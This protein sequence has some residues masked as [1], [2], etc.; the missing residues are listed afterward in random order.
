MIN[1]KPKSKKDYFFFFLIKQFIII[2]LITFSSNKAN[3]SYLNLITAS[4]INVAGT[5][6]YNIINTFAPSLEFAWEN[7]ARTV[8]KFGL[9]I[10]SLYMEKNLLTKKTNLFVEMETYLNNQMNFH[11]QMNFLEK[12]LK[13]FKFD[14]KNLELQKSFDDKIV[15]LQKSFDDKIVELKK[16]LLE[17][18]NKDF[19]L[20]SLKLC[21]LTKSS[22]ILACLLL[23]TKKKYFFTFQDFFSLSSIIDSKG[24]VLSQMTKL[25]FLIYLLHQRPLLFF[26]KK[27]FIID[28]FMMSLLSSRLN[29]LS[30]PLN[31]SDPDKSSLMIVSS[32]LLMAGILNKKYIIPELNLFFKKPIFPIFN[33]FFSTLL[34]NVIRILFLNSIL[35]IT[36]RIKKKFKEN[37]DNQDSHFSNSYFMKIV[38]DY[39]IPFICYTICLCF[40]NECGKR[41]YQ[42]SLSS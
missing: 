19:L 40:V 15:E 6:K 27:S 38:H 16:L 30:S 34:E 11:N 8:V 13:L 42:A 9:L 5:C 33:R 20:I 37:Y 35:E 29:P 39:G 3:D 21:C 18:S 4:V 23:S 32:L 31:P 12:S 7:K 26:N 17:K 2:C 28:N 10:S 41:F 25:P 24:S 14:D 1:K 36:Y 22:C